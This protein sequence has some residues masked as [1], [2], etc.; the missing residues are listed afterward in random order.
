MFEFLLMA[1]LGWYAPAGETA[2]VDDLPPTLTAREDAF[3]DIEIRWHESWDRDPDQ[4]EKCHRFAK[5]GVPFAFPTTN[6]STVKRTQ[7]MAADKSIVH[8][9]YAF[10]QE[11]YET[12]PY[13]HDTE[14]MYR[15]A[16]LRTGSN[17]LRDDGWPHNPTTL[18]LQ[19]AES[20]I[21]R[22]ATQR[23]FRMQYFLVCGLDF[24][25][26]GIDLDPP[27]SHLVAALLDRGWKVDRAEWESTRLNLTMSTAKADYLWK[28]N[29]VEMELA[30]DKNYAVTQIVYYDA[31][32]K[33]MLRSENSN[34]QQLGENSIWLP[35]TC[36]MTW[37]M[38]F[39]D[40]VRDEPQLADVSDATVHSTVSLRVSQLSVESVSVPAT[41]QRRYD[42]PGAFRM[43]RRGKQPTW[44]EEI[45]PAQRFFDKAIERDRPL[46]ESMNQADRP[47]WEVRNII[48]VVI[49]LLACGLTVSFFRRAHLSAASLLLVAFFWGS[50]SCDGQSAEEILTSIAASHANIR[51][52]RVQLKI[53]EDPVDHRVT[54][55]RFHRIT[56][57]AGSPDLYFK[58]VGIDYD[59]FSWVDEP[60]RTHFV[61][62]SGKFYRYEP[63]CRFVDDFSDSAGTFPET[64]LGAESYLNSNGI[65]PLSG[66]QAPRYLDKYPVFFADICESGEAKKYR[67]SSETR[68]GRPVFVLEK[69][70]FD[71]IVVDAR[72]P[73]RILSRKLKLEPGGKDFVEFEFSD[74]TFVRGYAWPMK[75]VCTIYDQSSETKKAS[76][77]TTL[78]VLDMEINQTQSD[79]LAFLSLPGQLVRRSTKD[80]EAQYEQRTPGGDSHLDQLAAW[81]LRVGYRPKPSMTLSVSRSSPARP[82]V[83]GT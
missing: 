44:A 16:L 61:F 3:G 51:E 82:H 9:W 42:S 1:S 5:H 15:D 83:S 71:E 32:G 68:N 74:H 41:M 70:Q 73:T 72:I 43:I 38:D 29:R 35:K 55:Y 37:A 7:K 40:L 24:T 76:L 25:P 69:E 78:D 64:L 27:L 50:S 8:D 20:M 6:E 36:E 57:H 47:F 10:Q 53:V 33:P 58:D 19:D 63:N 4:R 66:Y 12:L 75:V 30:Q 49:V 17:C 21:F 56:E 65:W 26:S 14:V 13:F 59:N 67:L 60:K 80:G 77:R 46:I 45:V 54:N 31:N 52:F 28:F 39:R 11:R 62:H 81:A 22:G 18:S 2:G 34:F 79:P 48:L 23:L